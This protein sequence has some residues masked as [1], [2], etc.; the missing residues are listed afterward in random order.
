VNPGEI[1]IVLGTGGMLLGFL[2]KPYRD[3]KKAFM[4]VNHPID[5]CFELEGWQKGAAGVFRWF[6]DEIAT[7]EVFEAKRL[8]IDPYLLLDDLIKKAPVGSGGLVVLPYFATAG[9]PRWNDDARGTIFGLSYAHDRACLTRAFA[10]G[11]TLE[12]KDMIECMRGSNL[13]AKSACII[14]GP[15]KCEEWNQIQADIY[16]I[17][18]HVPVFED[19]S[20]LGCTII[21]AYGAGLFTSIQEGVKKIIRIKKQYEP[22]QKNVYIYEELYD[23]Y[24]RIYE[25]LNSSGAFKKIA[26]LQK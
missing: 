8:G 3:P 17:P 25:G 15:T 10:E 5:G 14:G 13:T 12:I 20:I 16:G 26:A 18:V 23:V 6:R 1:A 21:G 24:V 7:H 19:A 11:I 2:D 9:T 22:I 4:I